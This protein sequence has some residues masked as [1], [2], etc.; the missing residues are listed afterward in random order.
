MIVHA[1]QLCDRVALTLNDD[2]TQCMVYS[3]NHFHLWT[4]QESTNRLN[5]HQ[6]SL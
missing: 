5:R 1:Y 6:I 3:V 4:Y 2:E